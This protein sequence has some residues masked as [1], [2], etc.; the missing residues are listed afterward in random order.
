MVS[1][2]D[3]DKGYL[4]RK[5]PAL[6]IFELTRYGIVELLEIIVYLPKTINP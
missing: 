6:K 5:L 3:P 2:L 1:V 4:T